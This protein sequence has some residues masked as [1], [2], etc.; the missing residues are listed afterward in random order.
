VLKSPRHRSWVSSLCLRPSHAVLGLVIILTTGILAAQSAQ[1]QTF[2]V[3]YAFT[4]DADGAEPL[5]GLVTDPA[6]NLYGTTVT[7]G[8]PQN[9]AGV[10]FKLDATGVETVLATFSGLHGQGAEPLGTL[11]R[12]SQGN[13]YGTTLNGGYQNHTGTVFK[14]P[15]TGGRVGLHIFAKDGE[16]DGINPIAG[17]VLD[18]KG[19]L[20]GTTTAGGTTGYGVIYKLH[21][22]SR[23]ETIL[24]TFTGK[25]GDG[26]N[27]FGPL[28]R[29]ASGN[30]YGTTLNGGAYGGACG[31]FPI[32]CG[33]VF[34]MSPAGKEKVLY[35]F[36]GGTD[37]A[38]PEGGL[39]RDAAGNL[40]GTTT[41]GGGGAC[42]NGSFTGCGT[43]FKVDKTGTETVL[44]RFTGGTD[45]ANP[46][47][48][49][50]RDGV[51]NL[52]GTTYQGGN[53]GCQSQMGGCGT[54]FKVDTTGKETVLYSFTG[55]TDGETPFSGLLR[56][57]AGDLYGTTAAGG[58]KNKNV[59]A[60]SGCGVV[61]KIH[62]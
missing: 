20:Y 10:V 3:L 27:G 50:V 42:Q 31:S 61:F 12:D 46:F 7:G 30:L 33:I 6:G 57:A 51:G 28:I 8:T 34:K 13:L 5:S 37:G 62:P 24:H 23:R 16:L 17:V 49:L 1:P 18:R 41:Y 26:I 48:G 59:C 55:G 38:N 21:I 2:S 45:G 15:P 36:T 9:Q 35:R 4:G 14:V 60:S 39:V 52:Y 11:V 32:G 29:D 53:T 25:W 43:V 54:V 58:T 56:D 47:A 40:Y 19:N 44:Y 22:T